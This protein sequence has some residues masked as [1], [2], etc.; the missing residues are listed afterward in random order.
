MELSRRNILVGGGMGAG[1]V[2]AWGLWPR[3]YPPSLTVE[4]GE[5]A[6]GA[7]LKIGRDGI[8]TVAVPQAEHGQGIA[9]TL[10]QVVADELGADWRTVAVEPAPISPLY[11]NPIGVDSLF[12]GAF[13]RLPGDARRMAAA[14]PGDT[15]RRVQQLTHVRG[16]CPRRRRDRSRADGAGRRPP[17]GR[18]LERLRG[19]G[20]VH[21]PWRPAAA[22]RRTGRGGGRRDRAAS[23]AAGQR[24]RGKLAGKDVPRLDRPPRSMAR[25][26]SPP[27]SACPTWSMSRFATHRWAILVPS[28]STARRR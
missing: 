14:R 19:E 17:L 12:E 4:P 16:A 24:R 1:L 26:I 3:A 18:G 7:W 20:R 22:L 25:P 8:V 27:T 11:A 10:A 28:V 5:Q 2:V 9:T 23:P 15:D 6:F 21:R 13:G